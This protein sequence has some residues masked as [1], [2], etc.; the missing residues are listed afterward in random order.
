MQSCVNF[1]VCLIAVV[2]FIRVV[3]QQSHTKRC[4]VQGCGLFM[5]S[6]M[7]ATNDFVSSKVSSPSGR[8][9]SQAVRSVTAE[10]VIG[11]THDCCSFPVWG[12]SL[13]RCEWREF[14]NGDYSDATVYQWHLIVIGTTHD[15]RATQFSGCT[16][17]EFVP[18]FWFTVVPAFNGHFCI[19]ASVPTWQ[20]SAHRRDW[21][22]GVEGWNKALGVPMSATRVLLTN[23]DRRPLFHVQERC[24]SYSMLAALS[25]TAISSL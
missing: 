3:S 6:E 18:D 11:T 20:V 4:Q 12:H 13:S 8:W 15:C 7:A 1:P 16:W 5:E 10:I 25:Y 17:I 19:Q 14:E 21:H 24:R 2:T 9:T 23:S 22:D